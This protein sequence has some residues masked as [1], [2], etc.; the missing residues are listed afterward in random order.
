MY[1]QICEHAVSIGVLYSYH[2]ELGTLGNEETACGLWP[3]DANSPTGK[4]IFKMYK[5]SQGKPRLFAKEE[6]VHRNLKEEKFA[7][8]SVR[9]HD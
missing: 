4:K 5:M 9:D 6:F 8:P 1:Q 7:S 3:Q 2:P